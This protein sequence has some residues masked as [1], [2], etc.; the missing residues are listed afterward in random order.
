MLLWFGWAGALWIECGSL[1][2]GIG[3]AVCFEQTGWRL[4]R[5]LASSFGH[6]SAPVGGACACEAVSNRTFQSAPCRWQTTTSTWH[7]SRDALSAAVRQDDGMDRSPSEKC[8]GAATTRV[9]CG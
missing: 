1:A 9:W 2:A 7:C 6:K 3:L 4:F 8:V 5:K